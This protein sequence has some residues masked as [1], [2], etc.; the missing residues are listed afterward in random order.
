MKVAYRRVSTVEQN[1]ARQLDGMAFDKE[2]TDKCSGKD[3]LRPKLAAALAFC[4]Q[5]K[6]LTVHSMDQ[7]AKNVI[8]LLGLVK[9]LTD[10]GV[11]VEFMHPSHLVFSPGKEDPMNT[12]LLQ[13]LGAVA[14]F[15]RSL[16]LERQREG[17]AIAKTQGVYK[18][19]KKSLTAEQTAEL[20]DVPQP[21]SRRLI[22]Q[23]CSASRG[24]RYTLTCERR[25][26]WQG[27]TRKALS[28]MAGPF[29]LHGLRYLGDMGGTSGWGGCL[30]YAGDDPVTYRNMHWGCASKLDAH[31]LLDTEMQRAMDRAMLACP[32]AAQNAE[33]AQLCSIVLIFTW[34]E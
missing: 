24:S 33:Q 6:T 4:R 27:G 17:I 21:V 23:R 19:R 18:G 15:E 11:T 14:Q 22:L 25:D 20:P 9:E 13:L 34:S 10:K 12:L 7:L 28:A 32:K 1:T 26:D 2:F 8:E 31:G 3:R 29:A 5:G 30:P 16:I